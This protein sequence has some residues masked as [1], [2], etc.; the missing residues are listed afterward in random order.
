MCYERLPAEVR[1]RVAAGVRD[2]LACGPSGAQPVDELVEE[3]IK[4]TNDEQLET[5]LLTI[6]HHLRALPEAERKA[7][8]YH[9]VMWLGLLDPS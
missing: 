4:V 1:E 5:W 6:D 8:M 2:V 9:L 3:F 7:R